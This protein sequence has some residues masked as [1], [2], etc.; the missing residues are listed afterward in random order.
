MEHMVSQFLQFFAFAKLF[1]KRLGLLFPVDVALD[2]SVS[3]FLTI[4]L[5]VY[6]LTKI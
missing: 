1:S 3:F 2:R 6:F 4:N 5:K